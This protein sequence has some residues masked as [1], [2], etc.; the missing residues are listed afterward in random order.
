MT[1]P[2]S[3]VR[4]TAAFVVYNIAVTLVLLL[5]LE[6]S[7]SVFYVFHDAFASRPN[8]ERLYTEYDRDLGWINLP[9]VYLANMYGPGKYLRTNAQR[10]RNNADFTHSPPQSKTR[11]I[12]SGDSFIL[13]FGVDNDHT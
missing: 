11:I 6:G 8:A 13:G 2:G 1:Q 5:V 12:C 3:S 9:S 10:F 4:R 7:A